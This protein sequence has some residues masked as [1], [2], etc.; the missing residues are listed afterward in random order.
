MNVKHLFIVLV[1]A[2]SMLS[3]GCSWTAETAAYRAARTAVREHP[4]LPKDATVGGRKD[5]TIELSKNGGRIEIP[6]TFRSQPGEVTTSSFTVWLKRIAD[7]WTVDRCFPA[8]Q[9]PDPV[10]R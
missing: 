9:L 8:G 2:A 1:M 3:A 10:T 4:G 7:T 5:A 6:Y